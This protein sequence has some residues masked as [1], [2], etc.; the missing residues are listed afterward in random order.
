MNFVRFLPF[1]H[2]ERDNVKKLKVQ[3]VLKKGC[4]LTYPF[5]QNPDPNQ[6]VKIATD[7]RDFNLRR[8]RALI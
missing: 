1:T 5:G 7:S 8:D 4:F 6:I 3:I 2:N